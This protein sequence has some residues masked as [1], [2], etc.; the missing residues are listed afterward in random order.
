MKKL[1]ESDLFPWFLLLDLWMF[2]YQVL[3][4]PALFKKPQQN[5]N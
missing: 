4:I 1:N 5:W 2:L 3:F